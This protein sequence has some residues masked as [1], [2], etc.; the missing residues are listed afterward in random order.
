MLGA[1]QHESRGDEKERIGGNEGIKIA[2]VDHVLRGDDGWVR[3]VA[4]YAR[5]I[6]HG[7]AALKLAY[8][9]ADLC[10]HVNRL[11]LGRHAKP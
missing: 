2:R 8:G 4:E 7:F 5:Q 1:A 11:Y 9:K 6:L 3:R 10:A